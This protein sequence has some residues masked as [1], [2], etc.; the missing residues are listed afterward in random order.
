MIPDSDY[1]NTLFPEPG[2]EVKWGMSF[3]DTNRL[4]SRRC[5]ILNLNSDNGLRSVGSDF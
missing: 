4:A 1:S 2:F 3:L 5:K